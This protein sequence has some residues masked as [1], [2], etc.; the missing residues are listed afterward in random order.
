[1]EGTITS[2]LLSNSSLL[3][4]KKHALSPLNPL[5]IFPTI[6]FSITFIHVTLLSKHKSSFIWYLT[7]TQKKKTQK[8]VVLTS[9]YISQST[10][11]LWGNL[12]HV[13]IANFHMNDYN[14]SFSF[15]TKS[16]RGTFCFWKGEIKGNH[17]VH[18]T[19][20]LCTLAAVAS[21]R[22]ASTLLTVCSVSL[23]ATT[24]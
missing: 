3:L 8:S 14:S 7:H 2:S 15:M 6:Y 11:G 17:F 13:F 23:T 18:K 22:Y 24:W 5:K 1:M 19:Y 4:P 12:V 21:Y 20:E 10:V 16:K 9:W